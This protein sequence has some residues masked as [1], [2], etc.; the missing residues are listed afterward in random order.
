MAGL[1]F[2][3]PEK[4]GRM[5]VCLE[6]A[7][8]VSTRFGRDMIVRGALSAPFSLACELAG[9]EPLLMAMVDDP[10]WVSGLLAYA[11]EIIKSYGRAFV[12]RGLGIILFDSHASPPLVSP[13]LYK[14]SCSRRPRRSFIISG[15]TCVFRSFPISWAAIRR[16][17]STS[18]SK[19]E[20]TTSFATSKADLETFISRLRGKDILLR[21]NLDPRFLLAS[22]LDA[23]EARVRAVFAAGRR[24]PGF[25]LGTGILPYDFPFE[26]VV[27]VREALERS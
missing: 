5:P 14:R 10:R 21:T 26:K 18:F 11:A 16:S 17:S 7:E 6:A 24:H 27:S 8:R 9:A 19:R 20:R 2:P 15:E 23:I 12:D 25:M 13:A 22:P 3:N 1:R 4:D